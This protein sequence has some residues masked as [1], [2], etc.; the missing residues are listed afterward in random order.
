[1]SRFYHINIDSVQYTPGQEVKLKILSSS[2][3]DNNLAAEKLLMLFPD[4]ISFWG[5]KMIFPDSWIK[6]PPTREQT[7]MLDREVDFEEVRWHGFRDKPSRY[8]SIF[9]F[10]DLEGAR[11]FR[12]VARLHE[13]QIWEIEGDRHFIGDMSLYNSAS[14]GEFKSI[15]SRYWEGHRSSAPQLEAVIRL[16]VL[17][18]RLV[19][20]GP[21]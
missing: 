21:N 8:Q 4:G 15:A 7:V 14:I 18:R 17:I 13:S 12:E 6:G 1:M 10:L 5:A 3:C 11:H 20:E 16:P 19:N 9:G 2:N